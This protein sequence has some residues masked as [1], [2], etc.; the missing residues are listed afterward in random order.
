MLMIARFSLCA[1]ALCAVYAM[2]TAEQIR[3]ADGR[4]LQGEVVPNSVT[5]EG[6]AFRLTDTGGRVFL[7]W[8]QVDEALKARLTNDRDPDD[9]LNLEVMVPGARL[10]LIDGSIF[11]GEITETAGGYRVVNRD[12][13]RGRL[14]AA[15]DVVEEGFITGIQIDATSMHTELEALR[16][17]EDERAPVETAREYYELARIADRLGLYEQAKDYV[18]LARAAGADARLEARL[19][20]YDSALDELIRQQGLLS[21]L[22]SAR[23]LSQRR[24]YAEAL[25][26]LEDAKEE[27][28]PTDAV[29][30]R[31]EATHADVDLDFT[32][33]VINEWFKQIR[34]VT[35]QKAREPGVS[36][37]DAVAWIRRREMDNQIAATIAEAVGGSEAEEIR[38]R[39]ASRIELEEQG[40]I[41]LTVRR[42]SFGPDGWY[43]GIAGGDLPIAGRRPAQ[44]AVP[45]AG[46]DRPRPP[47]PPQPRN[48]D[49][50]ELERILQ[51]QAEGESSARRLPAVIP[52]LQDWWNSANASTRAR[53]L[54]ALYAKDGGTMR[55]VEIDTWYVRYK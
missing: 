26:V 54:E 29:L 37:N 17:A 32:R 5:E 4:Y 31:W 18:T 43:Q 46:R 14:I 41:R 45:P 30:A 21:A 52:S 38:T 8:N 1:L 27:F 19:S 3:L 6:F 50:R 48:I 40:R 11:E 24:R 2:A 28:K 33:H 13:P 15:A 53:W 7:R 44:E 51:E 12:N 36:V 22:V 9:G 49:Y 16:I 20:E 39:F 10:E 35:R 42:A 34:P 25:K 55:V 23:Q 47:R